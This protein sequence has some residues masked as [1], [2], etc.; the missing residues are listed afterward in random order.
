MLQELSEFPGAELD[1]FIPSRQFGH[2]TNTFYSTGVDQARSQTDSVLQQGYCFKHHYDRESYQFNLMLID[3]V[4]RN[5]YHVI[6][7]ERSDEASR[8]FSYIICEWLDV[9]NRENMEGLLEGPFPKYAQKL[10]YFELKRIVRNQ[11]SY[12]RWFEDALI[13]ANVEQTFCSIESIF[14]CGFNGLDEL[15]RLCRAVGVEAQARQ[16]GDITFL[17]RLSAG[18]YG[19]RSLPSM[20][21]EFAELR[22][23]VDLIVAQT[24]AE[25]KAEEEKIAETTSD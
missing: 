6:H 20:H 1:P 24:L 17:D 8:I 19:T 25:Q 11:I 2:I 12:R 15:Y 14:Q 13:S 5:G 18:E 4:A 22:T 9:W 7:L 21:P 16:V 3:A 10:D 23:T